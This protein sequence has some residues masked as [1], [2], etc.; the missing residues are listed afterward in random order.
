VRRITV[1]QL[2]REVSARRAAEQAMA[3]AVHELAMREERTPCC[4][5]EVND[6]RLWTSERPDD[7][8]LACSLCQPCPVRVECGAYGAVL[9]K[10]EKAGVYGGVD[11]V[12]SRGT[13]PK[14][15]V[16]SDIDP[17]LVATT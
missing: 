11:M 17:V 7:R 14:T 1:E 4:D 5:S 2:M 6:T 15:K 8:S 13:K 16:R 10:D 12:P 3:I 9:T